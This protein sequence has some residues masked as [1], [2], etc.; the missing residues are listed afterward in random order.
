M[1]TEEKS[2]NTI[3]GYRSAISEVH[4]FV[5]GVA[6]GSHPDISHM[7]HAIHSDKPP[8][9]KPDDPVNISLS[10]DYIRN[11]GS[12]KSMSIRDLSV[13]TAFLMALVTAFRPSDLKRIDLTTLRKTRNS[14][15]LECVKLKEYNIARSHSLSTTKSL[16]KKIYIGS[17]D[18]D[19]L[20][21]YNTLNTLL[22]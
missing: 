15:T 11:L 22:D 2:Y 12:N 4:D 1:L 19:E 20:C 14:I 5:D 7:M 13:K 17:Y 16:C 21:S 8:P 6:I 3:A 18:N 10:L 9:S